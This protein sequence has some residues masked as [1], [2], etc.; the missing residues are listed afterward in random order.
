[1]DEIFRNNFLKA[2]LSHEANQNQL[3]SKNSLRVF[4]F[5]LRNI[6]LLIHIFFNS[7][8]CEFIIGK[9]VDKIFCY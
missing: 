6:C 1:M 7:F 8:F 2:N 3:I 5:V 9:R 4:V